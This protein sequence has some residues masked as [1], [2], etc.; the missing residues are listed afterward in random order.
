M[1]FLPRSAIDVDFGAGFI[2]AALD[3]DW[4]QLLAALLRRAE[5]PC[6]RPHVHVKKGNVTVDGGQCPGAIK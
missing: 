1:T 3:N 2:V 5:S 4:R 6:A